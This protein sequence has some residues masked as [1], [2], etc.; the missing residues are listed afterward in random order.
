MLIE[1]TEKERKLA[2]GYRKFSSRVDTNAMVLIEK[3]VI[4]NA[5]R[6]RCLA[7]PSS[8]GDRISRYREETKRTRTMAYENMDNAELM[9]ANW[10]DF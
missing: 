9:C 7:L 8:A 6:N 5:R 2:V 4:V 3:I 1:A 10:T